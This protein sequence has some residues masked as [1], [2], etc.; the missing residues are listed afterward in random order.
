MIF[1]WIGLIWFW[2]LAR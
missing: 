2:A 1:Y